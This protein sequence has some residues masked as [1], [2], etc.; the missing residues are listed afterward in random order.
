MEENCDQANARKA[1]TTSKE[2]YLYLWNQT[3]NR[4]YYH[5]RNSFIFRD[6]IGQATKVIGHEIL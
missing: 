3:L 2:D 4:N 5:Y 1:S 6:S